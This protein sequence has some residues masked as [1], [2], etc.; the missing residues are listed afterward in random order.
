ML[1]LAPARGGP[2]WSRTAG[3]DTVA[4]MSILGLRS[5]EE[6]RALGLPR[7]LRAFGREAAIAAATGLIYFLV[8]GSVVDRV[9][10]ATDR[11]VGLMDLE[12]SLG[13]FWEPAMQGW[14]LSS[15]ALIDLANAVYFWTHMPV[16]IVVAV[17]LYWRRPSVYRLIRNAFVV[18]AAIALLMYFLLPL[19]P[20]RFF[21]ELGFV[22]TMAL[23]ASANYQ[24]QEVGLFVNPFAALPSLHFGW[25]LLIGIALW[26]GR[27]SGRRGATIALVAASVLV[28]GQ[29]LAVIV[30]GNHYLL[31]V[32]AG[33]AVAGAGMAVSLMLRRVASRRGRTPRSSANGGVEC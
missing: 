3:E 4:A 5:S 13:L 1:S 19:A 32:V 18:S 12:R 15:R 20:P 11:A 27:P 7:G 23:Y 30:T 10:E 25:A 33:L 6:L 28:A 2:A 17:A 22:D 21:P 14:I 16:I 31:D 24:A 29:F 8:R 26:L 9:G